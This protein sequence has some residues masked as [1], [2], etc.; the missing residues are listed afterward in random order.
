ML[1]TQVI[2][3]MIKCKKGGVYIEIKK[4]NMF[5]HSDVPDF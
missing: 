2:L 3:N 1:R 5:T 4:T